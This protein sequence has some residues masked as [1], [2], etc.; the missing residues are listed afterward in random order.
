[1][2]KYPSH[3]HFGTNTV[4]LA[5]PV[6]S[7]RWI[8]TAVIGNGTFKTGAE[9]NLFLVIEVFAERK[10]NKMLCITGNWYQE[11]ERFLA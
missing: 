3:W 5:K 4:K 1:M 8:S 11:K 6:A 7:A 2:G 10:L 9:R